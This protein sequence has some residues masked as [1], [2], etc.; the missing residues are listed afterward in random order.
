M[1]W[2]KRKA[3]LEEEKERLDR[4]YRRNVKIYIITLVF[5]TLMLLL[6]KRLNPNVDITSPLKVL[7]AL[8]GGW[9]ILLV[10]SFLRRRR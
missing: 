8:M 6:A 1:R 7:L 5:V 2:E 3:R 10:L 4:I 9:I